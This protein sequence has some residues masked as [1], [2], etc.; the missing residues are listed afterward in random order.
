MKPAS[1]S[2]R[3]E[4]AS[5]DSGLASTVTSASGARPNAARTPSSRRRELP[6][7]EQRR[8]AAAEEDGVGR[9]RRGRRARGAPGHSSRSAACAKAPR[10]SPLG[11][12]DVGVEVAVRAARRAERHVHVDAERPPRRGRRA[13]RAGR[14]PSRG[15]ARRRAAGA[16]AGVSP[17]RRS[18]RRLL[19][20][21]TVRAAG[22]RAGCPEGR[23]ASVARPPGRPRP[24]SSRSTNA[25]RLIVVA[26]VVAVA[27]LRARRRRRCPA[28]R[29]RTSSSRGPTGPAAAR[30]RSAADVSASGGSSRSL[31]RDLAVVRRRQAEVAGRA[32]RRPGPARRRPR[33]RCASSAAASCAC[34][35]ACTRRAPCSP[36]RMVELYKTPQPDVVTVVM[37][38]RG[39]AD[40]L[41]QATYVELRRPPGR[42]HHPPRPRRPARRRGRRAHA[43][44]RGD[45]AASR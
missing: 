18:G 32:G 10:S 19:P 34:A 14:A 27:A 13:P 24:M 44:A 37:K 38:A 41:E 43:A 21:A 5:T 45:A 7:R 2:A 15:R 4:R 33:A 42:A 31:D 9:R 29:D 22:P 8:R 16:R 11:R 12:R 26:L 30:G 39:F 23:V 36:A 17:R 28:R 20:A 35:P 40:L 3:S 1:R 25:A 6:G